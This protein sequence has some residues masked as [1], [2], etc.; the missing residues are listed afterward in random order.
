MTALILASVVI[1]IAAFGLALVEGYLRG[2]EM[3]RSVEGTGCSTWNENP[4]GE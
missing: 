1:V 2:R 3:A 4:R